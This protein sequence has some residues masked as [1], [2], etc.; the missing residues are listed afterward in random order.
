M[1]IERQFILMALNYFCFKMQLFGESSTQVVFPLQQIDPR[2]HLTLLQLHRIHL[3]EKVKLISVF[4][5]HSDDSVA[6]FHSCLHPVSLKC[7]FILE[8]NH[9]PIKILNH[10]CRSLTNQLE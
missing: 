7:N 4:N 10:P 1:M 2:L 9:L 3:L 8:L 6:S 5:R